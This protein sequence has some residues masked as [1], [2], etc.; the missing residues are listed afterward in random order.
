MASKRKVDAGAF[1]IARVVVFKHR[2]SCGVRRPGAVT[3]LPRRCLHGP[4]RQGGP[5]EMPTYSTLG[6]YWVQ[7]RNGDRQTTLCL[8]YFHT[9]YIACCNGQSGMRGQRL[10]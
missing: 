3:C 2:L 5:C 8:C 7:G 6:Q 9:S 4:L 10:L 1:V